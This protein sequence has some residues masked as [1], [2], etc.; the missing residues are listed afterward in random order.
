MLIN[1]YNNKDTPIEWK[2]LPKPLLNLLP[3]V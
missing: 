3:T 2:K 1:I